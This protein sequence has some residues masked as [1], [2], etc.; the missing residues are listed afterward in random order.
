M[1]TK[2]HG[3][4]EALYGQERGREV[5]V[6]HETPLMFVDLL[7]RIRGSVASGNCRQDI[8]GT[9]GALRRLPQTF[10]RH[11]VGTI[12]DDSFRL[13]SV[14]TDGLDH[15]VEDLRVSAGHHHAGAICSE[16]T[17]DGRPDGA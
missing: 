15:L 17:A 5:R 1:P 11:P 9:K 7:E 16:P 4:Q 6:H 14:P 8:G 12:R 13:A 10:Q 3:R 2:D